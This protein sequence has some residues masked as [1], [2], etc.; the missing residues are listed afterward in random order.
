MSN[1]DEQLARLFEAVKS[2]PDFESI[3][4]NARL[5]EHDYEILTEATLD[6]ASASNLLEE[7][8]ND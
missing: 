7:L 3:I 8:I 2:S 5:T 6:A 1:T 4:L